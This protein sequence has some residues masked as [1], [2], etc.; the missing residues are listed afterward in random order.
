MKKI[1]IY[2][3]LLFLVFKGCEAQKDLQSIEAKDYN[4]EAQ[5]SVYQPEYN[6]VVTI[7][8]CKVAPDTNGNVSGIWYK[9]SLYTVNIELMKEI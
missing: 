8:K 7:E 6:H 3:L 4:N 5:K 2:L 9:D 1:P